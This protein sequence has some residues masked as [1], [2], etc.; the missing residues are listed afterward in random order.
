MTE[1]ATAAC[2]CMGSQQLCH[3]CSHSLGA[4][5]N[6]YAHSLE[7]ASTT[8]DLQEVPRIRQT[9]QAPQMLQAPHPALIHKS[10]WGQGATRSSHLFPLLP[11]SNDD[12][13]CPKGHASTTGDT[14]V[15]PR[16]SQVPHKLRLPQNLVFH[17]IH[18][19][20]WHDETTHLFH[21]LPMSGNDNSHSLEHATTTGDT[22]EVPRAYQVP[23]KPHLP[24]HCLLCVVHTNCRAPRR[25]GGTAV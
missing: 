22:Q 25:L 5:E 18:T 12:D 16:T 8:R 24:F 20:V 1:P 7:C 3:S 19:H 9:S 6:N 15:V 13:A 21:S 11:T 2:N 10:Q 4:N 23:H 14:Q 17:C